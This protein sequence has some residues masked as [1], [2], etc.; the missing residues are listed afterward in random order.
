MRESDARYDA[1]VLGAGP[2]GTAAAIVLARSGARCVIVDQEAG[3]R[4]KPGEA[5]PPATKPL[6]RALGVLDRHLQKDGHCRSHGND[7]AWGEPT[8]RT[9]HFLRDPRGHGWH[10]DRLRFDALL[11]RRAERAGARIAIGRAVGSVRRA[12]GGWRVT[13]G[14]GTR[15]GLLRARWL[16]DC[17]GRRAWAARAIGAR[18]I[19]HDRLIAVVSTFAP[20]ANRSDPDSMTLV[21]SARDGWWYTAALPG[22]ERIVVYLTDAGDASARAARTRAGFLR[23]LNDTRHVRE[24]L[25]S[26]RF[27][28]EGAPRIVSADTSRLD[29]VAGDAWVAAG[30]AATSFDPLSSQGILTALDSGMRAAESIQS[31]A[32]GNRSALDEYVAR[33][34]AVYA[35]HTHYKQEYYAMERR[36]AD[37]PFWRR[38]QGATR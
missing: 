5:L 38:R 29:R 27:A 10:V 28:P 19:C 36:W 32:E 30:D 3:S 22:G 33:V 13:L 7:S 14:Q 16:I 1:I 11:R 17:T 37:R 12:D 9:T 31:D 18:R 34:D 26:R 8:L 15:E 35:L 23:L 24:R 21:E 2:A 25:R 6:L 4:G 20:S